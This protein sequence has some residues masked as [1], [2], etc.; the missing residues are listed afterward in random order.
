[1]MHIHQILWYCKHEATDWGI[2]AALTAAPGS[3]GGPGSP[4]KPTGPCRHIEALKKVSLLH[5][6]DIVST[7]AVAEESSTEKYDTMTLSL[8]AL[9]VHQSW[10]RVCVFVQLTYRVTLGT[11]ISRGSTCTGG[12]SSSW[13]PSFSLLTRLSFRA[14]RKYKSMSCHHEDHIRAIHTTLTIGY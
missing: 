6:F 10:M 9:I 12:S 8:A 5:I 7:T 2:N 11:I 3:P 13:G 14:L 1:M 4:G